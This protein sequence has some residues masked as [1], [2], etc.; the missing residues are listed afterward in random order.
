MCPQAGDLPIG[1]SSRA[2][3][4]L[5]EF[6]TEALNSCFDAFSSREPVSTPDQVRGRLS[7]ENALVSLHDLIELLA[8]QPGQGEEDHQHRHAQAR[9]GVAQRLL[10]DVAEGIAGPNDRRRGPQARRHEVQR[11]E[12]GPGQ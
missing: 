11:Q 4:V 7:L 6:R 12:P 9:R 8:E 1:Q 5:I 3:S 10:G 2:L